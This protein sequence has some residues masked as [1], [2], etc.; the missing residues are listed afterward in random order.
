MSILPPHETSR[1]SAIHLMAAAGAVTL[2]LPLMD[3]LGLV[4]SAAAQG[5]AGVGRDEG[6][7]VFIPGA[8]VEPV[9]IAEWEGFLGAAEAGIKSNRILY[10]KD[11][12]AKAPADA[13]RHDSKTFQYPSGTLRT[14][15][16]KKS[17]PVYHQI[18]FETAIY[19][20][21]G[22]VTLSPL[23]GFKREAVK[24][25]AGDALFMPSGVLNNPKPTQDSVLLLAEVASS[26]EKP[27]GSILRGDSITATRRMEWQ[28]DGK[29]FNASTP[30]EM[31]KAPPGALSF[32]LKRYNFDGNS[33]RVATF[34]KGGKGNVFTVTRTDVLIYIPKGR[35]RRTEGN[36]TFEMAAGDTTREKIGNAGFWEPLEDGSVFIAIDA[37]F[38]P[39]I[40]APSLV[41]R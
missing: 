38:N 25:G 5:F 7:L 4:P 14:L 24:I 29:E 20:L 22:D 9:A 2:T 3:R 17:S 16:F 41:A 28:A 21:Q 27:Q 18:T 30:E 23:F 15:T 12:V 6:D 26:N 34:K 39:A 1:R 36:K 40:F 32:S 8:S 35:F 33:I 37:P 13:S 10:G 31:E 11:A 19:V